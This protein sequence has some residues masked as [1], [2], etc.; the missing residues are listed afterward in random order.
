MVKTVNVAKY[1]ILIFAA[2]AILVVVFG[3]SAIIE[4]NESGWVHVKQAFYTGDMTVIMD[5]GV[6]YQLFGKIKKY[7]MVATVGFGTQK[8]EGSADIDAIKVI[9]S[10]GSKAL[11]DGMV[12]VEL[13]I[14]PEGY[15]NLK[16]KYSDGFDHFIRAG[17]VPVVKNAVKLSANLRSAQ[18]AYTTLSLFQ[19]AISDQLQYGMYVTRSDVRLVVRATGDTEYQKIT[20]IAYDDSGMPKRFTNP[21]EKLGCQVQ[22]CVIEVPRFDERVNEMIAKRKDEAM[23]TELAKQEAI[24]AKQDAIT[25]VEK[26]RA[27]VAK[28]EYAALQVKMTAVTNAEREKEVAHQTRLKA[29]EDA[30]ATIVKG[31]AAAKANKL[32]VSAGLTPQERAVIEK[33]IAIGV[34]SAWSNRKV[35]QI[36]QYGGTGTGGTQQSG[37]MDAVELK[38]LMDVVK[39]LTASSLN[40]VTKQ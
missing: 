31:E 4:T 40:K 24:R 33:D 29:E 18:D 8:G 39:D 35:P 37:A 14:S 32:L 26:G 23:K 15:L 3:G 5:P 7:K 13:P 10:D 27:N 17:I 22:E 30:L 28:A 25:E 36:V 19:Q 20:E 38:M 6:Y 1:G 21:F 2:I 12:R 11:I 34:A 9:F 16:E